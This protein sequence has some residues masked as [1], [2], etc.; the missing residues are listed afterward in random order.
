[1]QVGGNRA[2]RLV[3]LVLALLTLGPWAIAGDPPPGDSP[4]PGEEP[5]GQ[6][7][8][9]LILWIKAHPEIAFG[10]K[11]QICFGDG[12]VYSVPDECKLPFWNWSPPE[13]EELVQAFNEAWNWYYGQPAPF[14]N[15]QENIPYPFVN[16]DADIAMDNTAP[17]VSVEP[18]TARKVFL[19]WVA[20]HLVA[21]I[22]GHFPW[23]ILDL[24]AA[25]L[26][27]LFDSTAMMR[28]IY[29]GPPA[30][31]PVFIVGSSNPGHPFWVL[32]QDNLSH[33]LIAPPRFTYAFLV[34]NGLVGSDRKE[35]ITRV[36]NWLRLNASHYIGDST[37][38]NMEWHWQYRGLPPISRIIKGTWVG[39][40][41]A[42]WGFK[43]WT[44][45]C[46]GTNGFLRE[47]L[48]AANI[49]VQIVRA[50]GHSQAYFLT[51]GLYLDHGDNPYN[52]AFKNSGQGTAD[53]LI[54]EATYVDWFGNDPN[55]HENGCENLGRRAVELG[56]N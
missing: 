43:H 53:L 36:M 35:T 38:Q 39:G 33:S 17:G 56:G 46:H 32:R 1:M 31:D 37:Y 18:S 51:E 44:A 4:R 10:I 22:G 7:P 13:K 54:D 19:A 34:Q 21:E 55:N 24:D 23:S 27:V 11:W 9:D 47:V 30:G 14:D 48:R 3:W 15:L 12:G 40:P 41:F 20:Q 26:Q 52:K 45:G 29:G 42:E 25:G 28:L 5:R 6:Q 50:C 16:I 2:R 49:P 8:P